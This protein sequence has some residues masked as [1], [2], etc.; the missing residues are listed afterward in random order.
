MPLLDQSTGKMIKKTVTISLEENLLIEA[1]AYCQ[2]RQINSIKEFAV[3]S[4][5]Y[6][7]KNDKD[8]RKVVLPSSQDNIDKLSST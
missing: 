3:K 5:Q 8:W 1:N 4:M 2:W 7:L 6:V